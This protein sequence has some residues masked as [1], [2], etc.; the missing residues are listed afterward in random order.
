MTAKTKAFTAKRTENAKILK[1]FLGG[2]GALSGSKKL[3]KTEA[4]K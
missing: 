3:H 1:V 2:L 4:K